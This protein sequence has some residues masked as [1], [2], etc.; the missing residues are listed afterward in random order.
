MPTLLETIIIKLNQLGFFAFLPFILTAAVIYGILRRSKIFG[1]PEK[2]IAVNATVALV[3]AFMVWAYPILTGTSI[4]NYQRLYSE[5]FYRGTLASLFLVFG[6]GITT[7][8]SESLGI[9]IET[10]KQSK[11]LITLL[12]GIFLFLGLLFSGIFLKEIPSLQVK[13]DEEILSSAIFLLLFI[14]IIIGVIIFT[15]KE[16][17]KI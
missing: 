15:G 5:F 9:K 17:S 7:I 12:L 11:I 3:S 4:E 6:I 1:E 2:N 8:V 10:S 16:T 14:S 13:I